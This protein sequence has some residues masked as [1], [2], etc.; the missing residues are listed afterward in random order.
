MNGAKLA[1]ILTVL[2]VFLIR[3]YLEIHRKGTLFD[4]CKLHLR[5]I[6]LEALKS[7]WVIGILFTLEKTA[8]LNRPT[9]HKLISGIDRL[10]YALSNSCF[11]VILW[12]H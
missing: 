10:C 11:Y 7:D 1:W 2:Q 8:L 4:F 3:E 9:S 5:Y 6:R 12:I